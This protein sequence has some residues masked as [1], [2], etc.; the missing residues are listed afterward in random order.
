MDVSRLIIIGK[1]KG[2]EEAPYDCETWGATQL[3]IR[4]DVDMVVDM[5]DYTNDRWGE[6]ETREMLVARE[7]AKVL[8]IP[9]MDLNAYPIQ[10]VVRRFNTTFFTNTIDYMIALA[11]LREFKIIELYGVNMAHDSEYAY[12]RP[13]IHYWLGRAEEAGTKVIVHEPSTIL[14]TDLMYGYDITMTEGMRKWGIL[15]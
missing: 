10:A 11:L 9:Y 7:R 2:W 5:N 14:K 13:G 8:R 3:V 1:A 15:I 6:Q 12:Q 4:R